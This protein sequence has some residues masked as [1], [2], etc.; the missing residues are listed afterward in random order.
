MKDEAA[1][2]RLALAVD[3]WATTSTRSFSRSGSVVSLRA[4]DPGDGEQP[5][6]REP[7]AFTV[8]ATRAQI[9]H[10]FVRSAHVGFATG[11]CMADELL[12]KLGPAQLVG[13]NDASNV[14]PED[15]AH[16]QQVVTQAYD[17]C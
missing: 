12:D 8:L 2:Q 1:A 4:C 6:E 14:S 10:E 9:I 3:S 5:D 13:L 15:Q 16:I 17:A 7:R 11:R